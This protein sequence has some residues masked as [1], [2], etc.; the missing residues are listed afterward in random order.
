M[1]KLIPTTN[2]IKIKNI[3]N[4]FQIATIVYSRH[5][6]MKFDPI[7]LNDIYER[8]IV[9]YTVDEINPLVTNPGRLLLSSNCIYFQAY[10]NIHPVG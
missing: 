9:D 5:N 4:C 1:M 7:W 8:V 3:Y 10:N 2:K 6:R